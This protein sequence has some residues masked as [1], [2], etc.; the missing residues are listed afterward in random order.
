TAS[1]ATV[2]APVPL[3]SSRETP[4]L[5]AFPGKTPLTPGKRPAITARYGECLMSQTKTRFYIQT[6]GCQMNVADSDRMAALL[7]QGGA[8]AVEAPEAADVILLNKIGR[9]HV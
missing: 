5:A 9:A 8:E 1:N 3:C 2:L 4:S 7:E 6:Y